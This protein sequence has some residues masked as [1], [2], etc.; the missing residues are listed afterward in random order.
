MN[1]EPTGS[2]RAMLPL[3]FF[4]LLFFG[5]GLY[6]YFQGTEFAFYQTKA[7]VAALPAVVLA[8]LLARGSMEERILPFFAGYW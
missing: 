6:H 2:G 8:V 3:C 5:G 1:Y 4:V 7:P